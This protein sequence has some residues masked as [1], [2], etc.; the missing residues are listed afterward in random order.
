MKFLRSKVLRVAVFAAL[1]IL[2]AVAIIKSL[3]AAPTADDVELIALYQAGDLDALREALKTLPEQSA[4]GQFLRGA[5]ESDGEAARF[6]YDQTV[7]LYQGSPFEP[8][9]LERLWQYHLVKGDAGMAERYWDFL[10]SRHPDYPGLNNPP[11]FKRFSTPDELVEAPEDLPPLN[12]DDA[13]YWTV[14]LGA[15][16]QEEGAVK[17][18]ERA[19]RWGEV[20]Y[21]KKIYKG[22]RLTVV[23][24]GR[25]DRREDAT[26][27]D[28]AIRK[29]SDLK[30]RIVE[31]GKE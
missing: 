14:Q 30:G 1:A 20:R 12:S 16:S 3:I 29:S 4:A 2:F 27:L 18:G 31:V 10:T 6:Y 8:Y 26:A 24:V 23:Q 21:V 17:V 7:A 28:E 11:D 19:Q 15:F 25:F 9:A 5:F 22:K 13:P